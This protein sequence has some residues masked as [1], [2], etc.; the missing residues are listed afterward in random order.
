MYNPIMAAALVLVLFVGCQ[1]DKPEP[2]PKAEPQSLPKAAAKPE[3]TT[4]QRIKTL[5]NSVEPLQLTEDTTLEQITT[6]LGKP[7]KTGRDT[8]GQVILADVYIWGEFDILND[9]GKPT[10]TYI[11]S[12]RFRDN[13]LASFSKRKP[14]FFDGSA[15]RAKI[16]QTGHVYN[17]KLTTR[18]PN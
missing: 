17:G 6:A 16:V 3:P 7:E 8:D 13:R 10:T 1:R 11:F 14:F 9:S 5:W 12:A 2:Q 4:E 18:E 15:P